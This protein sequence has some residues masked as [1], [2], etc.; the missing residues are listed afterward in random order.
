MSIRKKI[1]EVIQEP[2]LLKNYSESFFLTF[3]DSLLSQ[4]NL[5]HFFYISLSAKFHFKMK[6]WTYFNSF[7]LKVTK[8]SIYATNLNDATDI[9]SK[10]LNIEHFSIY[11]RL[12]VSNT[13]ISV[14]SDICN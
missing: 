14:K 5:P 11:H 4:K 2:V 8:K 1:N 7:S 12:P 13:Q 3:F 9:K 10:V 6:N